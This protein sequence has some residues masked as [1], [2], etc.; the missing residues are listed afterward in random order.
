MWHRRIPVQSQAFLA[1]DKGC[2]KEAWQ[3]ISWIRAAK[4]VEQVQVSTVEKWDEEYVIELLFRCFFG[5]WR[6]LL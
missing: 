2:T 4:G 3:D 5:G 6:I 1:G